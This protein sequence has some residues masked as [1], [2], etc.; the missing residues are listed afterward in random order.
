MSKNT[1]DA[2]LASAPLNAT[3][4]AVT[5]AGVHFEPEAEFKNLSW[6]NCPPLAA[7]RRPYP[8]KF[9]D[10]TGRKFGRMT[11]VG[12]VGKIN[13]KKKAIWAC[14]C[15]CGRY[16]GRHAPA[17]AAADPQAMCQACKYTAQLAKAASGNNARLRAESPEARKW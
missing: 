17:I 4:G 1:W 3:A 8:F 5:S 13:P 16:E 15:V 7:L 14:R 6:E 9:V 12:Y 11:V 10:M 2:V